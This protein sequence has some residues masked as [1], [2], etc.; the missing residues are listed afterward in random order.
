M[1]HHTLKSFPTNFLW[2]ASTSAYQTEGAWKKDGK[3]PSVIDAA[4]HVEGVADFTVASDHYHRYKEDIA[5]M[6][7]MG[8]KAY[9][10]SV[11]WTRIYP[12]GDGDLNEKG[13]EFYNRLINEIVYHGMEPILT[14]YHFDLPLAL[15]E[16]GGWSNRHTVKAFSTYAETLFHFFGDR[17]SHWL[18]INE[19]NMI[20]LHGESIG[21]SSQSEDNPQKDLYQQNHHMLIA[22][23]E[24][25]TKCHE[26]LPAAKI[27]PAP[28]IAPIY[29]ASAKPEDVLA[30]D[31][32]AS[33]RNWLYLDVAVHGHYN[34]IA[35]AYLEK[36]GYT[37]EML[38]GDEHI[39]KNASPDFIAINYYTSQTAAESIGDESDYSHTGDQHETV[40]EPGAYRGAVNPYLPKTDFGWEIDPIGFRTVLR[41]VYSRYRLP[42]IVTENGLGAFDQLEENETVHD[43]YRIEFLDKH[44]TH[45][46]EAISDGVDVIGYCPWAAIDLISTHQGCS[47]RYGFIYVNRAEFDLKDLRRIR[48]QSFY[49]YQQ[50]IRTNG[51]ERGY[52]SLQ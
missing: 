20:I 52:V 51:A 26:L 38:P 22:Q 17:V 7:E 24:A 3:G 19:Q 39:L 10:F 49:W 34:P 4:N 8:L 30:A 2:G 41:E 12:Q 6:A 11:A 50:V 14:M 36:K 46:Q 42:I 32:Y 15:E 28:N 23:A 21:T 1:I 5:L 9:R 37:P 31:T 16:R 45:M 33:I 47:K 25:M 18:T 44:I 35:W 40:G 27:G 48:K 13:I 29:P 43:P